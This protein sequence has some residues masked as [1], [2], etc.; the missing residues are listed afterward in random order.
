[1]PSPFGRDTGDSS[2]VL[3][4]F[5]VMSAVGLAGQWKLDVISCASALLGYFVTVTRV[6]ESHLTKSESELRVVSLRDDG[7]DSR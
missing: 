6:T 4:L 5:L 7:D 1:M 3:V 2:R